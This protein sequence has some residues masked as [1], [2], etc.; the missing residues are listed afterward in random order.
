MLRL[1]PA[2]RLHVDID[3]GRCSKRSCWIPKLAVN[4][5]LNQIPDLNEDSLGLDLDLHYLSRLQILSEV[6]FYSSPCFERHRIYLDS[7]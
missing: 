4:I 5:I 1:G 7:G 2:H 6:S 3:Y